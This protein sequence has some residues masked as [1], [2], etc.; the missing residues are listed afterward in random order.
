MKRMGKRSRYWLAALAIGA[1]VLA[2]VASTLPRDRLLAPRSRRIATLDAELRSTNVWRSDHEAILMR[3]RPATPYYDIVQIDAISLAE[4]PLT[5]LNLKYKYAL[6][7]LT[8]RI[9]ATTPGGPPKKEYDT[10]NYSVSPSGSWITF[11]PRYYTSGRNNYV[12]VVCTDFEGRSGAAWKH[13]YGPATALWIEGGRRFIDATGGFGFQRS[14][15]AVLYSI[16]DPPV[17]LA[18]ERQLPFSNGT[19]VGVTGDGR[20][21]IL[22]YGAYQPAPKATLWQIDLQAAGAAYKTTVIPLPWIARVRSV[23]ISHTGD[24]LAWA[25]EYDTST[26]VP[27]WIRRLIP[28]GNSGPRS[29]VALWTS[30][31]DGTGW[32]EIGHQPALPS[33]LE[34]RDIGHVEWLPGDR[35]L[36]YTYARALYTVAAAVP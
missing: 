14:A 10:P 28:R 4:T 19:P 27:P 21:L 18:I 3:Y 15:S 31:L 33:I 35:R 20:P 12:P 30:R 1:T 16:H 29:A 34:D 22:S 13:A 25:L 7:S 5:A 17:D 6:K 32:Q 26:R 9:P 8:I 11:S 23:A 24:R 2:A 36:S